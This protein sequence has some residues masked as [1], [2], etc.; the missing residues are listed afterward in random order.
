MKKR[1]CGSFRYGVAKDIGELLFVREVVGNV[2]ETISSNV[3]S[4]DASSL[5]WASKEPRN[6]TK[7][8]D[9][10]SFGFSQID[11]YWFSSLHLL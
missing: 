11:H 9:H 8:D 10:S 2:S 6:P 7:K 3:P 5:N 1:R 4:L